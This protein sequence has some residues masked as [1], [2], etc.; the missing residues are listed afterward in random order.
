MDSSGN[1]ALSG[2]ILFLFC[3]LLIVIFG[4]HGLAD[5]S[6]M[7]KRRDAMVIENT[8]LLKKNMELYRRIERLKYDPAFVEH[9]ARK[10]MGMIGKGEFIITLASGK[11]I[12]ESSIDGGQ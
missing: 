4:D 8:E 5:L 2:V 1:L 7:K 11:T 3:F 12:T 6:I 9:V 10:E